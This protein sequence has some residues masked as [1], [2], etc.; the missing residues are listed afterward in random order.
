MARS[1]PQAAFEA[2]QGAMAR[3][4]W[5]G[6]FACLHRTDLLRLGAVALAGLSHPGLEAPLRALCLEHGLPP[7][8]LEGLARQAPE[9]QAS[10]AAVL[11]SPADRARSLRHRDLVKAQAREREAAL[12]H[13]TDLAGFNARAE[14]LK[15]QVLGGGSVSST[16][17]VGETLHEVVVRGERA[18]GLRRA[19]RGAG[20]PVGFART[21][22]EWCVQ[23]LPARLGRP[24]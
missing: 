20:V 14:R 1:T 17:F 12:K 21:R 11:A 6:F 9:L 7:A 24:R 16:L 4:D 5:E 23:L 10:A 19:P 18:T 3:G 15:R 22:G 13:L 2:A 8:D